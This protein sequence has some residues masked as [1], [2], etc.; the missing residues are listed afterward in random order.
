MEYI[1]TSYMMTFIT[2]FMGHL[3]IRGDIVIV[4]MRKRRQEK[5]MLGIFFLQDPFLLKAEITLD[6]NHSADNCNEL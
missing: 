5:D 4:K 6:E 3:L 2:Q 1:F